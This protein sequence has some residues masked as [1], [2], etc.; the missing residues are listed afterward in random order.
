MVREGQTTD[1]YQ[2][3][4][5]KGSMWSCDRHVLAL[6]LCY[7]LPHLEEHQ[8]DPH[9]KLYTADELLSLAFKCI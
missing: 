8:V 4:F 2:E 9:P 3:L 7:S 1:T 5:H 6:K